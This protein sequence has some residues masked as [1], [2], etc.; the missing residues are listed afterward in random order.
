MAPDGWAGHG[1]AA[2]A[3]GIVMHPATLL[4]GHSFDSSI[5]TRYPVSSGSVHSQPNID[6]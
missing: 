6:V 5:A 3:G 1:W 2:T 4:S